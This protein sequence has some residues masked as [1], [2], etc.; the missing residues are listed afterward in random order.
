MD[1]ETEY[2]SRTFA[3]IVGLVDELEQARRDVTTLS[4]K[5]SDAKLSKLAE[6]RVYLVTESLTDLLLRAE[7][8]DVIPELVLVSWAAATVVVM[9]S[10]RTA[11]LMQLSE[12]AISVIL[13]PS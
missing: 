5:G 8:F 3:K 6:K 7:G 11:A 2:R 9:S 12:T 13:F 4:K 1:A 10:S